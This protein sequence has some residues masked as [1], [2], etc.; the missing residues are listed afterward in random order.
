MTET[1]AGQG[2]LAGLDTRLVRDWLGCDRLEVIGRPSGSGWSGCTVFVEA[3]GRALVLRLAPAERGMFAESD[4]GVQVGCQ[5]HA[6]EHGLPVPEIVAAD[7][8]GQ[9]IGRPGYAMA[10]VSGQVPS[11]DD[12]PFTKAGF[13]YQASR[14]E[15]RRYHLDLIDRIADLH[16]LPVPAGLALGPATVDHLSWCA[17]QR[18]ELPPSDQLDRAHRLLAATV[19]PERAGPALLWGDARPANTVVG[20][21]FRVVAML[22]WELAATGAPELDVS[23]LLEMNR[24]RAGRDPALPGFLPEDQVWQRWSS[25]TG[26]VP[27]G[28]AWFR[29]F[30]AYRV[31]LL[32]DLHLADQVRVGALP[33]DHRVRTDNRARRRLA[34]LLADT[35]G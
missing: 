24:M 25:R 21:D 5:R 33:A 6:R 15:Q 27:T 8:T 1:D 16:R 12:P 35:G 3:D 32:M 14:D 18:A 23:W 10:R 4:L 30:A 22:D 11:D 19:V 29:L 13:L 9:L 28:R 7:L 26:R 34:K 20:P 17:D 31:A 2:A